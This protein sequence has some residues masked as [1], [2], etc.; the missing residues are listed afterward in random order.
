MKRRA[1]WTGVLI[2]YT[3][4]VFSNSMDPSDVSSQESSYVLS[5]VQ[6]FLDPM[7]W[8][9]PV[10][11]HVIRK[12]AHFLE[13]SGMGG[14]LYFSLRS[15]ELPRYSTLLLYCL[16]GFL[17]PFCDET[18]QLFAEGRSGQIS[19]VWLDISGVIFGSLLCCFAVWAKKNLIKKG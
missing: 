8:A 16:I 7:G 11:E 18:I 12:T 14:L 5:V 17:I 4:F 6:N 1:I 9:I 19:D 10:T 13:Y 3:L 2:L 15:W